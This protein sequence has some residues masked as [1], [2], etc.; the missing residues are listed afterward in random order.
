MALSLLGQ[1]LLGGFPI[2]AADIGYMAIKRA[3]KNIAIPT[4]FCHHEGTT[5][6]QILFTLFY[7]FRFGY[8]LDYRFTGSAMEDGTIEETRTPK[9]RSFLKDG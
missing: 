3:L 1:L 5:S 8:A 4:H 7:I 6:S 9:N 2:L